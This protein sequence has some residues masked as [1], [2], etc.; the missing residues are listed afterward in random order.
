MNKLKRKGKKLPLMIF[1]IAKERA[2]RRISRLDLDRTFVL[3][4]KNIDK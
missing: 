3:R 2:T 1:K 4:Y